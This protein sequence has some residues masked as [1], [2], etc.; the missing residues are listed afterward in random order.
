M[1]C[2]EGGEEAGE[3]AA[4]EVGEWLSVGMFSDAVLEVDSCLC[5]GSFRSCESLRKGNLKEGMRYVANVGRVS[6]AI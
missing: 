2:G 3:A 4:D 5:L 1:K 6:D